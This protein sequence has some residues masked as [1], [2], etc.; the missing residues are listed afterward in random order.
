MFDIKQ[1]L[2]NGDTVILV[3]HYDDFEHELFEVLSN[4]FEEGNNEESE[5]PPVD[6]WGIYTAV[7]PGGYLQ[8]YPP[9]TDN[10]SQKHYWQNNCYHS[11]VTPPPHDPPDGFHS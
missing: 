8:T 10:K 4:F 1:T 11:I 2:N 5:S 9:F 7:L 6:V 3:G